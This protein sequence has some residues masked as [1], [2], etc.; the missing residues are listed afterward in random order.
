MIFAY[1]ITVTVE[2]TDIDYES[3]ISDQTPDIVNTIQSLNKL[4]EA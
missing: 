3:S 4:K 2:V 1:T